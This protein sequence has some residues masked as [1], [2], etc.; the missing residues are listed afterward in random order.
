M[1]AMGVA[2]FS[3][4][5]GGH[6]SFGR[7]VGVN[8]TAFEDF[9]TAWTSVADEDQLEAGKPIRRSAGGYGVMLVRDRGKVHALADR[10]SHRGCSLAEGSV[11]D[12]RITCAC[13]GSTY[14]LADG[15]LVKG[16]ATA[17]QPSLE[18]RVREGRVEVRAR[19]DS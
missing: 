7:G 2:G 6:L 11:A 1:L 18:V 3:A 13:H 5:L 8:Q 9:P 15:F 19:Q 10:C 4:W 16:P 12:G 14:E 17:P